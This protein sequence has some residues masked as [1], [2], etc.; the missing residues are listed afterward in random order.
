MYVITPQ[1][2][3]AALRLACLLN[4]AG[5]CTLIRPGAAD[6][7]PCVPLSVVGGAEVT[8]RPQHGRDVSKGHKSFEKGRG[9]RQTD[10]QGRVY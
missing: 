9:Q 3:F 10:A 7:G 4:P 5:E 2:S 1:T 6:N 8:S